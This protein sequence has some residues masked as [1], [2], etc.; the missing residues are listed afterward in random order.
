M[1]SKIK[2]L[3]VVATKTRGLL[4][5]GFYFAYGWFRYG[6]Y[7]RLLNHRLLLGIYFQPY[8][9]LKRKRTEPKIPLRFGVAEILVFVQA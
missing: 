9:F 6:S 4:S 8:S 7:R 3:D 1:K 5:P 2:L